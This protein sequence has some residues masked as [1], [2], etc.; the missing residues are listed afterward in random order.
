MAEAVAG[1]QYDSLEA[2]FSELARDLREAGADV[3]KISYV[4][5]SEPI[6]ICSL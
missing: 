3:G 4:N 2:A 6:T 5:A 1:I